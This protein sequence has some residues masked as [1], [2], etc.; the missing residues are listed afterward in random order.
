MKKIATKSNLKEELRTYNSSFFVGQSYFGNDR[1]Q[2]FVIFQ[3]LYKTFKIPIG[4][5]DTIV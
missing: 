4:R 1:S 3:P 5:K 2:H